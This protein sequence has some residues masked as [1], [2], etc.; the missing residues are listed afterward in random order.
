[1]STDVLFHARNQRG[2]GHFIRAQNIATELARQ[3]QRCEI[4]I[5]TTQRPD[6]NLVQS[7]ATI[8]SEADV[9]WGDVVSATRPQVIVHDTTINGGIPGGRAGAERSL[10]SH[11]KRVLVLRRRSIEQHEALLNEP[12]LRQ[13]SKFVVPHPPEEFGL[14]LPTWIRDRTHFVGPIGRSPDLHN[15]AAVR[16]R[17]G[18]GPGDFLVTVTVGGGGFAAQ[19]D[20][21]FEIVAACIARLTVQR[22]VTFLIVLGPNYA[23]PELA[24]TLEMLPNTT[25]VVVEAR[26]VDAIAASDL[27][28][29][30]GGYNTVT[31]VLLAQTPAIFIPSQRKLDDQ[32]ERVERIAATGAALVVDPESP[33]AEIASVICA[34]IGDC[35]AVDLMRASARAN[36]IQ[37][38]NTEAASVILSLLSRKTRC[39]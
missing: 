4:Q 31:E 13:V 39:L 7:P 19:A 8:T 2:L 16:T 30:E 35:S 27:V 36:Q 38:G 22:R 24:S 33:L 15:V 14:D 20:R 9:S 21:F 6:P 25:V 10:E 11:P 32:R 28:I 3:D 17:L 23:K 1:M 29:A 12:E 26:L 34:R 18:V 37:L 5:H